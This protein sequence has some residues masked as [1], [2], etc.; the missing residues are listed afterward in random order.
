MVEVVE[1]TA[2][3]V[4]PGRAIA[5]VDGSYNTK[6]NRFSYGLVMFVK[7]EELLMN[8]AF[9][10]D[11][12]ALMR[13]VA[14]EIMGA[15]QAM[16]LARK[17]KIQRLT[18]YHDYEGIAKWCTGQWRTKKVWTAK[19]KKFYDEVSGDVKIEFVKVEGHSGNKYNDLADS[20]ARE[21][22]GINN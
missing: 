11:E 8:K 19:Y 13:N 12:L 17:M 22:L 14:G 20:L 2:P 1:S 18:I 10:H 15:A 7:N 4:E 9:S 3:E 21:A 16:K 6:D 5:Y